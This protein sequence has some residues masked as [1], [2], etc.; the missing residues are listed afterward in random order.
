MEFNY[1]RNKAELFRVMK[2]KGIK[3]NLKIIKESDKIQVGLEPGKFSHGEDVIPIVFKGILKE[4]EKGCE[5][6]GHFNYGFYLTGLVAFAAMLIIVRFLW[7][8]YQRQADNMILCGI[9]TV[10]LM[11]V[12]V[13]V[14]RKAE[15]ARN[16]I[17]AFLSDLNVK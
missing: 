14:H 1:N 7:S 3:K 13:V 2:S 11:I 8:V 15:T 12:I 9:V 17:K 5:L 10:L 6:K 4:H 16:I